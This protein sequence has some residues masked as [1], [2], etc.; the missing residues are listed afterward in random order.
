MF[1]EKLVVVTITASGEAVVHFELEIV[2][3]W[4]LGFVDDLIMVNVYLANM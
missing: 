2:N 4:E 3:F 1:D